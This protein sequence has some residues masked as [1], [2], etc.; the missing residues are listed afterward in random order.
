MAV[1]TVRN[2][3]DQTKE[4]LRVKVAKSGVSLEKYVRRV[5][6]KASNEE[7]LKCHKLWKRLLNILAKKMEK[8]LNYPLAVLIDN[9]LNLK[10]DCSRY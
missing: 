9:P 10:N 6:Q 7:I 5:L 8:S 2:L 1:L 4:A 3:P